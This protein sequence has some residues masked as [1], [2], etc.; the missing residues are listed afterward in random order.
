MVTLAEIRPW[1]DNDD[2]S[3]YATLSTAWPH[4]EERCPACTALGPWFWTLQWSAT[5]D[6]KRK[7]TEVRRAARAAFSGTYPNR[8]RGVEEHRRQVKRAVREAPAAAKRAQ[9][10]AANWLVAGLA[11]A[12]KEGHIPRV[13]QPGSHDRF[14]GPWP[15]WWSC[16]EIA[17]SEA[18]EPFR[19]AL[20]EAYPARFGGES[21]SIYTNPYKDP[22]RYAAAL[23]RAV[24]AHSIV[25]RSRPSAHSRLAHSV[26]DELH[27]VAAPDGQTYSSLWLIDDLDLTAVNRQSFEGLTFYAPRQFQS[28]N[29]VSSLLPEAMWASGRSYVPHAEHGGFVYASADGARGDHWDTTSLLNERIG[30]FALAVRLATGSTGPN[31]MVWM[32]EPS[33]IHVEMPQAHPQVENTIMEHWRRVAVIKP[34]DLPGLGALVALIGQSEQPSDGKGKKQASGSAVAIALGRFSRTF[35]GMTW[36]DTVLDLATALEACLGPDDKQEISLTLRTRAGHL[37]GRNDPKRA[38]EIFGDVADLYNLRSNLVHGNAPLK[39][40]PQALCDARGY[41]HPLPNDRLQALLDRWRD[42]VRRAI[43]A[44]LLLADTRCGDALWPMVGNQVPVDRYLVRQDK[45]DEW[46]RRLVDEASA[47][48]LPVLVEPAPPLVD[49]LYRGQPNDPVATQPVGHQGA[50]PGS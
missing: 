14:D 27:R 24:I 9:I 17:Q 19:A 42:I 49:Y 30:V 43:C 46:C 48:G 7:P 16:V 40:T 34:E 36:Q 1:G 37:L 5:A 41:A 38:D 32:G 2:P 3:E 13:P 8:Y 20:R 15:N 10:E 35:T 29:I 45:R 31:R 26:I 23:L 11:Q 22:E 47:L 33:L 50:D 28:D 21:K 44:R 39:P 18:A 6:V 4:A 25:E 12:R